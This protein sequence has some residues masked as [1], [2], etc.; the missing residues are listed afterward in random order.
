MTE[1]CECERLCRLRSAALDY[2]CNGAFV[3]YKFVVAS[4][5]HEDLGYF[6]DRGRKL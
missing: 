6:V 1:T 3:A 5:L 2:T 4:E